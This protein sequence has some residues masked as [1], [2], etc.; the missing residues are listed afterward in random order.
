MTGCAYLLGLGRIMLLPLSVVYRVVTATRNYL[1]DRAWISVYRA[2]IPV[3]SIGNLT[4]GGTGKTP[5]VILLCHELKSRGITPAVVSRGYGGEARQPTEVT[6]TLP[7]SVVGDEPK[8][9]WE[10]AQVRVV[11]AR[12]RKDG[13]ALLLAQGVTPELVILD[14]GHQHRRVARDLNL[15]TIDVSSERAIKGFCAGNLLPYGR[16]RESRTAGLNRTDIVVLSHRAPLLSYVTGA[17]TELIPPQI[18]VFTATLAPPSLTTLDGQAC[19]NL[20]NGAKVAVLCGIGNPAG[21]KRTVESLGVVVEAAKYLGDH[22]TMGLKDLIAWSSLLPEVLS[23]LCTAKDAVKLKE[24]VPLGHQLR[25]Q[26]RVVFAPIII[27]DGSNALV[28]CIKGLINSRG[29]QWQT[30]Q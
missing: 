14:D 19:E 25:S 7:C 1:F 10:S 20:Q 26:I 28:E 24:I 27:Q 29:K 3:I 23:I 17:V 5:L 2:P 21:F 16:F 11:V 12:R 8:L 15:I 9:I 30:F 18:P 6:D 4:V 13:I 22:Q